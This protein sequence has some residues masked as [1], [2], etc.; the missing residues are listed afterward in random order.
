M[1]LQ[2]MTAIANITLQQAST[3]VTFS[4]IPSNYRDLIIVFVGV[5]TGDENLTPIINGSSV[6]FVWVQ[7]TSAPGTSTGTNNSIGRVATSQ[8][9]GMLQ[10]FDYSQTNK[11]KTFLVETN[12]TGSERRQ[13]LARWSQS[14]AINT[15]GLSIRT[16]LSFTAGS[17]FSLYGRIA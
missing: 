17:T 9:M 12:V 16:G 10:F 13:L 8:T 7:M 6:D 5:G 15:L 14:A 1:A 2:S 11:H 3:S 4:G